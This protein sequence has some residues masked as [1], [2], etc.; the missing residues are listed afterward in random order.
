MLNNP[1]GEHSRRCRGNRFIGSAVIR[2]LL[3]LGWVRGFVLASL[4]ISINVEVV[5]TAPH[6]TLSM[7]DQSYGTSSPFTICGG[8]FFLE[9]AQ[10]SVSGYIYIFIQSD[11]QARQV[12]FQCMTGF[13]FRNGAC[14]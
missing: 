6:K 9:S 11:L 13:L 1:R 8:L 14:Q 4:Y 2:F 3:I 5:E 10:S 7:T 12:Q